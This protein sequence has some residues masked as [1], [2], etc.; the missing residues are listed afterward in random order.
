MQAGGLGVSAATDAAL[1]M[2]A[3][4]AD[5]GIKIEDDET[6]TYV[7]ALAAGASPREG[8]PFDVEVS[9]VPDHA[10][11][12]KTLT[13]QIDGGRDRG[14]AAVD[15]RAVKPGD[16]KA[17]EARPNPA[18]PEPPP[19]PGPEPARRGEALST[20]RRCA[21]RRPRSSAAPRRGGR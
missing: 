21:W 11:D 20:S 3:A 16:G 12:S 14:G 18:G 7:L 13:L 15:G 4:D 2:E 10:G 5:K 6:Q 19:A 8:A 17:R 9:A 1:I